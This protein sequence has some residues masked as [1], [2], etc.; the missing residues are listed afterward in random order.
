MM[1]AERGTTPR[2]R[3]CGA[4][5]CLSAACPTTG[6]ASACGGSSRNLERSRGW[7][8]LK[9]EGVVDS[10]TTR[11]NGARRRHSWRS[12]DGPSGIGGTCSARCAS[13]RPSRPPSRGSRRRRSWCVPSNFLEE[14]RRPKGNEKKGLINYT[15]GR[16][17]AVCVGA[18]TTS[19]RAAG[20]EIR[21]ITARLPR[22]RS[23][24]SRPSLLK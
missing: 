16:S 10:W 8:C 21:R 20:C 23:I 6:T 5:G 4:G 2:R 3:R 17:S 9:R 22:A 12:T 15:E 14:A 19:T 24:L 18:S 13:S 11:R 1:E 7:S